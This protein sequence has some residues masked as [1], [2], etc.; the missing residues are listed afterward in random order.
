VL[1]KSFGLITK[2]NTLTTRL[3]EEPVESV[4]T[5]REVSILNRIVFCGLACLVGVL[6]AIASAITAFRISSFF[7]TLTNAENA[8]RTVVVNALHNLNTPLVLALGAAALLAF[9][10]ALLLAVDE[11]H[12]LA[13]VG[14]PFSIGIPLLVVVLGLPLWIV[15]TTMLDLL[16]GKLIGGSVDEG[17]RRISLLLVSSISGGLLA[18]AVTFVCAVISLFVPVR[19]REDP[20]SL[21]RAFVWAATGVLMLV[22]A[23]AYFVVV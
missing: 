7:T 1:P 12:R 2:E 20:L 10:I 15:E 18:M 8:T 9:V 23:G 3:F 5:Q 19:R 13:S 17:A 14:L 6:P 16:D 21:R 4:E 11:K 22:F